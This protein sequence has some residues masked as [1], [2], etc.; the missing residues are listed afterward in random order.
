[1]DHKTLLEKVGAHLNF[2]HPVNH[3]R[4]QRLTA[5]AL[6]PLSIWPLV[7]IHHALSSPYPRMLEWLTSLPNTLALLAWLCAVLYHAAL[8]IQVVFEDYISDIP[9]R[10]RA[11][12]AANLFLLIIVLAAVLAMILILIFR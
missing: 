10:R 12:L 3:W 8:G 2:H 11:S 4:Y 6:I 1:M 7:L 5:L 9:V